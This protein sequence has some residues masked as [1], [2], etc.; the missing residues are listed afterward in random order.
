[1]PFSCT[2]IG[3]RRKAT[4]HPAIEITASAPVARGSERRRSLGFALLT[5]LT[6]PIGGLVSAESRAADL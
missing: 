5:D 1:L 6:E 4:C 2:S 3:R